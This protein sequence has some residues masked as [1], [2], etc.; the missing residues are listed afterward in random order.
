MNKITA[1]IH[2]ALQNTGSVAE[3]QKDIV[4]KMRKS[5]IECFGAMVHGMQGIGTK[6]RAA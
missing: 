4:I 2:Y 6:R 3:E 1:C 5:I